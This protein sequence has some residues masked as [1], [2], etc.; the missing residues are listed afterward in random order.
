[1][2]FGLK[3][4]VR[5]LST[6]KKTVM[7]PL[8]AIQ[9]CHSEALGCQCISRIPPGLIVTKAAE[10]YVEIG[11]LREST[12]RTSPPLLDAVGAIDLSL[13][14]YWVGDTTALPIS[15]LSW[16]TVLVGTVPGKI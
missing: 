15:A 3:S 10:K 9:N 14:V 7:R 4:T 1:M 6:G 2:S 13:K 5:A 12:T 8:P 11:K 16:A